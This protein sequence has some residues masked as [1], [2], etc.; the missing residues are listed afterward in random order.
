MFPFALE[1]GIDAREYWFY[2]ISELNG[3]IEGYQKRLATQAAMDYKLADLIGIS[4]SRLV[5]KD[6]RFPSF[7][8]A[9]PNFKVGRSEDLT[10]QKL[11]KTKAWLIQYAEANNAKVGV[12]N[13]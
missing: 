3:T 13:E 11:A 6:A 10:D 4:A 12:K 1:A 5:S 8:E 7:D 2:T 9:Y